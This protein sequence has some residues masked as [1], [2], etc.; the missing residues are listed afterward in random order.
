MYVCMYVSFYL[1]QIHFSAPIGT[2]LCTRLPH[3]MEETVGYVWT[4]TILPSPTI[5]PLPSR[6]P[7]WRCAKMAAGCSKMAAGATGH[8]PMRYIRESCT[9]SCDV[10]HTT[11]KRAAHAF[12]ASRALWVVRRKRGEDNGMYACT[13]GNQ[14]TLRGAEWLHWL[15][16]PHSHVH[17]C[18]CR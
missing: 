5:R 2:K 14:V 12:C 1:I 18:V 13:R 3:G 9:C 15:S 10:T 11:S 17:V 6:R 7:A 16:I 4:H 8:P